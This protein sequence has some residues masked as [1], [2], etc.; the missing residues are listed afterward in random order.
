MALFIYA[1]Y[2]VKG[3]K[4]RKHMLPKFLFLY[5]VG[6]RDMFLNTP[7]TKEIPH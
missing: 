4:Q 5:P 6:Y 2:G 3:G 7:V 1:A